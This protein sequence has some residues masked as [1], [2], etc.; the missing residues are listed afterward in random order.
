M[1][2]R[3][4]PVQ[5][6]DVART[7]RS[8]FSQLS[9]DERG[10]PERVAVRYG[11]RMWG[12]AGSR[13]TD[14]KNLSRSRYYVGVSADI[15]AFEDLVKR[16][17]LVAD[18]LLLSGDWNSSFHEVA[19]D[20][21]VR[22]GA[23]DVLY[24]DHSGP[25][26]ADLGSSPRGEEAAQYRHIINNHPATFIGIHSPDL[27]ALGRWLLDSEPLLKAG[28]AWYLPNYSSRDGQVV[29]GNTDR[30]SLTQPEQVSSI[31]YLIRD[32]RAIDASGAHP[33]KSRIVRPILEIELPF[34]DGVGLRD[35]S[36]ITISEF[37]NYTDFRAFL[38]KS[39]LE[40][41]DAVN[42]VQSE[43]ALMKIAADIEQELHSMR[44]QM[45]L[46]RRRRAV[47]V[48][49]AAVGTVGAVLA[50][51]YG[52][53]MEDAFK[54]IAAS[55]AGSGLWAVIDAATSNGPRELKENRW[56]YVWALSHKAQTLN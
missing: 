55:S 33:I 5:N 8:F 56:H 29:E 52:P 9:S 21:P 23:E 30:T 10:D 35:F 41:D 18:T 45:S 40:L 1:L 12:R 36:D 14:Q 28:L 39:L 13:L 43:Q 6:K 37:N 31:D 27:A 38:R 46:A 15:A 7:M 25:F 20:S 16:V 44:A 11:S 17:T 32:G 53:V 24:A 2:R 49:G 48:S 26:G 19:R 3:R 4:Q 50:A 54:L 47:A 34:I 51:V 22:R 42:A